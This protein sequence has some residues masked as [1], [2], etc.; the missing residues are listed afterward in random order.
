MSVLR[1]L[2]RESKEDT[3]HNPVLKLSINISDS[4]LCD[5]FF[6][7]FNDYLSVRFIIV[8]EFINNFLDD[9]GTSHFASNLHSSF[10]Q[11]LVVLFVDGV[12]ADPEVAEEFRDYL[13]ADILDGDT[14]TADAL[15]DYFISSSLF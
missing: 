8:F 1:S 14:F 9:F 12:S 10:N 7:S 13:L 15:F 4:E 5:N 6:D 2:L 11:L 3:I